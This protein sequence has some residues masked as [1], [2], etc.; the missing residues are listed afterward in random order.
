[1]VV[2]HQTF[3]VTHGAGVA[4]IRAKG[5]PQGRATQGLLSNFRYGSDRSKAMVANLMWCS[6]WAVRFI[7]FVQFY[8]WNQVFPHHAIFFYYHNDLLTCEPMRAFPFCATSLSC[9]EIVELFYVPSPTSPTA[10]CVCVGSLSYMLPDHCSNQIQHDSCRR[11][12][13]C[14]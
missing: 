10:P 6:V 7:L 4:G 3:L 9:P 11:L 14:H 12:L 5:R 13:A 2:W 1:M 8:E